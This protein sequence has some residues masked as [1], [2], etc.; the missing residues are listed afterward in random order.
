MMNP[1][2]CKVC[3]SKLE[4]EN[5]EEYLAVYKAASNLHD[6]YERNGALWSCMSSGIGRAGDT[7]ERYIVREKETNTPCG[8]IDIDRE[9]G[10][11][12]IDIAIL[13]RFRNKGYGY[14]AARLLCQGVFERDPEEAVLWTVYPQN[15]YSRKIAEKLGGQLIDGRELLSK[16]VEKALGRPMSGTLDVLVY[17]IR[18]Q[19]DKR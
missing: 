17:E 7:S 8:Y 13:P 4:K 5:R 18:R 14:E 11:P 6:F 3:L 15:T 12:S 10:R 16:I 2:E 1:E 19:P 9:Q